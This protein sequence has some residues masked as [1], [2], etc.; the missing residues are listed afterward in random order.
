MINNDNSS[1]GQ[2]PSLGKRPISLN[3]L[4]SS[5]VL[6]RKKTETGE[7]STT[8]LGLT[9]DKSTSNNK[10]LNSSENRESKSKKKEKESQKLIRNKTMNLP[11]QKKKSGVK[12][13]K[14]FIQTINVESYKKYNMDMSNNESES[15][16]SVKCRCEIF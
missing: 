10:T 5:S 9:T 11:Q 8:K 3:E 7:N 15:N 13:K 16:Q 12:F 14:D 6:R 2:L 4:E 1:T